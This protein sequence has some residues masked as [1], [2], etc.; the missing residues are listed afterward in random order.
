[1]NRF[2]I[3]L[4]LFSASSLANANTIKSGYFNY[5]LKENSTLNT[6]KK[7]SNTT[8]P[9]APGIIP[10]AAK[11]SVASPKFNPVITKAS[12]ISKGV[13]K[14]SVSNARLSFL[15]VKPANKISQPVTIEDSLW[16]KNPTYASPITEANAKPTLIVNDV[17]PPTKVT[18]GIGITN[19]Y[20]LVTDIVQPENSEAPF[21]LATTNLDIHS[22]PETNYPQPNAV[23]VPA[24]AWLFATAL[25][26]LG[27]ARRSS[28]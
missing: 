28:V 13:T 2:L 1:M 16:L 27:F 20:W 10:A 17:N 19:S 23:P 14:V 22:M 9:N 21:K 5:T 4:F 3:S 6:P 18:D 7:V 15:Y 8:K 12:P 11:R 26:L 25:G 24:A